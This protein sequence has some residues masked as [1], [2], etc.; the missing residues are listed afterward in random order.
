MSLSNK[1]NKLSD[2]IDYYST[3]L[4]KKT[5][6]I[7][8]NISIKNKKEKL[9]KWNNCKRKLI[10]E[11]NVID[12][13][14]NRFIKDSNNCI[15]QLKL[16]KS[17]KLHFGTDNLEDLDVIND[18]RDLD[19]FPELIL[20]SEERDLEGVVV[21]T[22]VN[23]RRR[24][25][26]D[27]DYVS[28]N[29]NN[30]NIIDNNEEN[31]IE[32]ITIDTPVTPVTPVTPLP[33]HQNTQ[34]LTIKHKFKEYVIDIDDINAKLYNCM[35]YGSFYYY[36][37]Y[38]DTDNFI[39]LSLDQK[40]S[41]T[42]D[43]LDKFLNCLKNNKAH[44][45]G[46]YINMA[47]NYPTMA[48]TTHTDMDIYINKKHFKKFFNDIRQIL[49]L[50]YYAFDISSPYMESFFR[51]NGLL[52]RV[53][54][55]FQS[56]K[57]DVLIIRD[58]YRIENV[59][60]NF[61]LTYCSVYLDPQSLVIKGN[62][63]D[64]LNKS[65]KL[66][67]E[68]AEKYLFNK[69][70]QNRIKKYKKRGYKTLIR[71][72][73]NLTIEDEKNKKVINN[74]VVIHK[75]LIKM[76]IK[77][78][79]VIPSGEF[80]FILSILEYSKKN[81]IKCATK[82]A[83][84]LYNDDKYY[85]Y[86][87]LDII[88][89]FNANIKEDFL[90]EL[91]SNPEVNPNFNKFLTILDTF[92]NELYEIARVNNELEFTYKPSNTVQILNLLKDS[93]ITRILRLFQE[94]II[95]ND[96]NEL[97][98]IY[99]SNPNIEFNKLLLKSSNSFLHNARYTNFIMTILSNIYE[100]KYNEKIFQDYWFTQQKAKKAT[101]INTQSFLDEI[102]IYYQND[103]DFRSIMYYDLYEAEEKPYDEIYEDSDNLLFV[104]EDTKTGFTYKF[105][106][107]TNDSLMEF[108][109]ECTQDVLSAPLLS[110]I[111]NSDKWYSQLSSPYNI[112]ILV[113][114]LY[115]AYSLYKNTNKQIREF[116]ISSPEQLQ[117]VSSIKAIQWTSNNY[118]LNIWGEQINLVSET[119]CGIGMK[120]YNKIMYK[121]PSRLDYT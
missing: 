99:K 103:I 46:G 26:M 48:N 69:F 121:V 53:V 102:K 1:L 2:K 64:M 20:D 94:D 32:N 115:Q 67:D 34:R 101:M 3:I 63:D 21:E 27:D 114:Q 106:T 49:N 57:I 77:Y 72:H 93:G 113:G 56:L 112:G 96:I 76:Y 36:V 18:E 90:E 4:N 84:I 117:H 61:D 51:K 9:A 82:I 66:N 120:V 110:Q 75:L 19:Q 15:S 29:Q 6:D 62:I 8:N 7:N 41:T 88:S 17:L 31:I 105:E 55:Y 43:T 44:L 91:A 39:Q 60:K 65:G 58:D 119:H 14:L 118:G 81:F 71:T 89:Y 97:M 47:T 54:L 16:N 116:V 50:S 45:A 40:I 87:I 30:S 28:I 73:I 23:V 38:N 22:P 35:A 25:F 11:L 24:L 95:I 33:I 109:L 104:L 107:L 13:K 100:T 79:N 78:K 68:Y 5:E 108:I 74:S 86:I 59:I 98:N 70:I 42:K 37:Y 83:T 80:I 92:K 52:S 12:N 85:Y 111:K 10:Q